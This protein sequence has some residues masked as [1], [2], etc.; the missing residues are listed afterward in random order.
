MYSLEDI[1]QFD[2]ETD[3]KFGLKTLIESDLEDDV[4]LVMG[5]RRY[6]ALDEAMNLELQRRDH[7]IDVFSQWLT[8]A[9]HAGEFLA[10]QQIVELQG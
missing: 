9:Q 4:H 8:N 1:D 10:S 5:Y 6:L 2:Y 7:P 3:I